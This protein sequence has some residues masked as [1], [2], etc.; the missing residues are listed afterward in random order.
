MARTLKLTREQLARFLPDAESIKQFEKLFN[1]VDEINIDVVAEA[2]TL[3]G[4]ADNKA[5]QALGLIAAISQEIYVN[6]SSS[7]A[8][9]NES[10]G[11]ITSIAKNVAVDIAIADRK[12]TE[13]ID[14]S[15]SALRKAKFNGVLTW[16]TI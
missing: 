7:D 15:N 14:A 9:I 13:A 1:V 16:L 4:N 8:K 5:I 6:N 3:A 12:S 10:I 2:A 11:L